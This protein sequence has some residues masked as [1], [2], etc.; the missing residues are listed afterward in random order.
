MN[1]APPTG[2]D[3]RDIH[4]PDPSWW[5]PAPGWWLLATALML[6]VAALI[7]WL[8]RHLQ[9]RRRRRALD[10][11]L[12]QIQTQFERDKDHVQLAAALSKLVRRVCLLRGGGAQLR[13]RAWEQKLQRLAP[14][15]LDGDAMAVLGNAPYRRHASF[16]ANALLQQS[17]HWL[18][19][20]M[21]RRD[22]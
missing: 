17:R 8:R 12:T 19:T 13:G 20:A 4:V 18:H 9:R 16:D 6:A 15:C 14:A 10:S 2:P 21:E 11:E 3:L 22:A 1:L 7:W 5:P